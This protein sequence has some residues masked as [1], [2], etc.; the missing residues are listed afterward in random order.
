M[1]K[2]LEVIRIEVGELS[3]LFNPYDSMDISNELAEY[4][5]KDVQE[6]LKVKLKLI[7]FL[8]KK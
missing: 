1:K 7:L 4:I 6:F 2:E 5:E 3:S 8:K